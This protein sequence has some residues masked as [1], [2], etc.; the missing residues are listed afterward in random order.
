M[1]SLQPTCETCEAQI[2]PL[3]V[4]CGCVESQLPKMADDNR[5]TFRR[6]YY[7]ERMVE[8]LVAQAEKPKRG[9]SP[10]GPDDASG[11]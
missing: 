10:K 9:R 5:G 1:T 6:I 11:D 8:L 2:H 4:N 7:L 3:E